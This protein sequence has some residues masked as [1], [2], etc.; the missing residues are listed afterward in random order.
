M[1]VAW[2][3]AG[4]AVAGDT[5]RY[6]PVSR[7]ELEVIVGEFR[8]LREEH[9][10]AGVES[11]VRRRMEPRLH[12]LELRFER[13]L[14]E[15][16]PD[17]ELQAAWR[18]HLHGD[19]P[20][21]AQ[22][23]ASRRLVF[24]GVAEM[25]SVVEIRPRADGDYDVDLDGHVVERL[26]GEGEAD[27][28]GKEVGAFTLDGRVFLETFAASRPALEALGEFVAEREP[29]PPWPFA[30]E[31]AADGLIDRDFGL[32]RRGHRALV[33]AHEAS[34]RRRQPGP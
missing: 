1:R 34:P 22:P 12:E 30:P 3:Q 17:E 7:D 24:R 28:F 21:P 33:A 11:S 5:D 2:L 6:S 15:W 4:D 19:A 16:A 9:R 29:H 14:H 25:G 18:A 20:E 13:L 26:L 8:H 31:L 10:R 23:A 27:A 32:T